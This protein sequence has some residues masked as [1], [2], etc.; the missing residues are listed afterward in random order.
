MSEPQEGPGKSEKQV[1]N[2]ELLQDGVFNIIVTLL[3]QERLV[4]NSVEEA[5]LKVVTFLQDL[6]ESIQKTEENIQ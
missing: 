4:S 5:N 6:I 3:Q 1:S 2:V